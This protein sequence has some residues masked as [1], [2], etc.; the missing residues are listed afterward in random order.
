VMTVMT[1]DIRRA[2]YW[3]NLAL[4]DYANPHLNP[5]AQV[6]VTALEVHAGNV[7]QAATG[8]GECI[9]YAY[10]ADNDGVLDNEDI[11]GFRLNNGVVQMRANGDV[12]NATHD[13][14]TDAQGN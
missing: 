14:C 12:T 1:N 2:G 8:A 10:D 4:S 13:S 9:V 7:E 6:D 3:G 5:F 11:R